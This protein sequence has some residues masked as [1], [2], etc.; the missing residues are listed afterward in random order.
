MANGRAVV[1]SC[2]QVGLV[3]VHV[4]DVNGRASAVAVRLVGR[5]RRL[6]RHEISRLLVVR[7]VVV[8]ALLHERRR[9]R[10]LRH[11]VE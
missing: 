3:R 9:V 6:P 10:I 8:V 5:R 2:G 1:R 11:R 4:L 7:M